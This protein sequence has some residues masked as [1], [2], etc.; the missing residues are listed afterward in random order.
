MG[1][2][3]ADV[4]DVVVA[5]MRQGPLGQLGIGSKGGNV[6]SGVVLGRTGAQMIRSRA[7][8]GT[9]GGSTGVVSVLAKRSGLGGKA[10]RAEDKGVGCA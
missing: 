10:M 8:A 7:G 4:R 2:G 9:G 6:M 1:S 3:A 5:S